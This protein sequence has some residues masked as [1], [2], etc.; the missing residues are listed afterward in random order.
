MQYLGRYTSPLGDITLGSDGESLIGLWFD[1]EKFFCDKITEDT[2]EGNLPVFD[3]TRRWLDVYFSGRAPDFT[4]PL[5]EIGSDFQL[6]VWQ[7]L[8][9]IPFGHTVTYGD[10]AGRLARQRGLARMSA[11]AVGGAVGH[12]AISII[13]PCHRVVGAN[14][15]LTGYA[16]GVDKKQKLLT[17]EGVDMSRLFVPRRGTAL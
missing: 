2:E 6:A 14:G 5:R 15:S 11:Q 3:T 9:T 4:P 8:R 12:N 13:V 17:L 1:G 10:I 16:G 7:I